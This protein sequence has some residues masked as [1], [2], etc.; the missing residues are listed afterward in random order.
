MLTDLCCS[1]LYP[2]PSCE[3]EPHGVVIGC[4]SVRGGRIE[5][6]DP[7]SGRRW[8]MHYPLWSYWGEQFGIVPADVLAS[9][10]FSFIC[11]VAGMK[12]AG[13]PARDQLGVAMKAAPAVA[14]GAGQIVFDASPAKPTA[15]TASLPIFAARVMSA[16]ASGSAPAGAPTVEVALAENPAIRL[17]VPDVA[18]GAGAAPPV[19]AAPPDAVQAAFAAP[20]VSAAMPP[21]LRTFGVA[22]G[23]QLVDA[24]PVA[25]LAPPE[26]VLGPLMV[27]GV[28]NVGAVLARSPDSLFHD[29]LGGSE[30]AALSAL[31]TSAEAKAV[32]VAQAVAKALKSVSQRRA[33]LSKGDLVGAE[34]Q[35]ALAQPLATALD[36]PADMVSA[37]VANALT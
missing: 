20:K 14:V 23:T 19:A 3:G 2:G 11:C 15:E 35:A 5:R 29:V 9:R 1:L 36:L 10:L 12:V 17:R 30:P 32:D 31:V 4:A 13:L 33:V 8:V 6:V 25:S 26:S 16:L 22:L 18:A 24:I 34:A 37:A 7:W 27:S 21:L 28:S